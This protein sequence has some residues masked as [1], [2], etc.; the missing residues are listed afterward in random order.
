MRFSSHIAYSLL[1]LWAVL[2][3][4]CNATLEDVFAHYMV[5]SLGSVSQAQSDVTAAKAMGINAFALNVQDA[6]A[7]WSTTAIGYLFQA[8]QSGDFK[9]FFSF[10]MATLGDP[11]SWLPLFRQYQ[12]NSAYY[13]H[14][15]RPFVSTFW[16][17]NRGPD[18][19]Q[20]QFK[21]VLANEGI[22]PFFVPDFDDWGNVAYTSTFWS[23]FPV[24]DGAMGWETA[25]P[26]VSQGLA[27]V[28]SANDQTSLSAAHAAG[29]VYMMPVSTVQF[30]H[31]DSNNN[32]YRRGELNL[33]L[34]MQQALQLQPDFL[35]L[36]TWND[37]GESHYFGTIWPES[38]ACCSNIQAYSNGY[39]HTAWQHVQ[40]PFIS[41]YKRGATSISSIT[42]FGAFA[43]AFWYH[44]ILKSAS[45]SSDPI[46]R[47]SGADNAQDALNVAVLLP[48]TTSGVTIRVTSGGTVIANYTGVA[49]LNAFFVTG[50]KTGSQMVQLIASNGTIMGAGSSTVNVAADTSGVCN[51]NYQVVHIA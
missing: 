7:S 15:N 51:F 19:W 10:D 50:I 40:A 26:T 29:K 3:T 34:R 47:P 48:S 33:A 35:E 20:G 44:T 4:E 9:L 39:D 38:I 42:P 16:G 23:A 25:W 14:N 28:S 32:W 6:T 8:A 1:S 5:G 36:L 31:L 12:S 17:G 43:G 46:G 24:V 37:A 21:A 45:C 22:N 18:Y 11:A 41:A 30:K 27:N 13:Y 2:I 49:G